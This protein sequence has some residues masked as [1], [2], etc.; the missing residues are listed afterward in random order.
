M[1]S[2]D[3]SRRADRGERYEVEQAQAI[4]MFRQKLRKRDTKQ[5]IQFWL[6]TAYDEAAEEINQ[7]TRTYKSEDL[8]IIN[9]GEIHM[10]F[11]LH[12]DKDGYREASQRVAHDNAGLVPMDKLLREIELQDT[13]TTRDQLKD[14]F[15][16]RHSHLMVSSGHAPKCGQ[17][18]G[19]QPRPSQRCSWR[20]QR[21]KRG[22]RRK[23][24]QRRQ[25]KSKLKCL[26][27]LLE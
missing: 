21:R 25:R 12:A 13:I 2:K 19:R 1:S 15:A 17:H 18:R 20:W 14:S 24:R 27:Q 26:L 5:T 23:G 9:R 6:S 4:V 7:I 11:K 16:S 3:S 8:I 22:Q 10:F